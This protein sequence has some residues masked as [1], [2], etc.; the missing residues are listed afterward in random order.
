ML[1]IRYIVNKSK[2]KIRR[3]A[4]MSFIQGL[5][6][7]HSVAFVVGAFALVSW[8]LNG[9]GTFLQAIGDKIPGWFGAV[10]SWSGTVTHFLNGLI[11]APSSSESK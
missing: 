8:V 6:N 7:A 4:K 3:I 1:I 2:Q 5:I 10:I 11:S 9:V